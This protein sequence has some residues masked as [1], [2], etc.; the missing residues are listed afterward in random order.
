MPITEIAPLSLNDEAIVV[1]YDKDI[2]ESIGLIKM[3][4]WVYTLT[5]MRDTA[6]MVLKNHKVKI[7]FDEIPFDDENI[8]K[9]LSE[10]DTAGVF[11][12]ESN[13]MTSFIK[14]M[15]P[16]QFEDIIAGISLFRPGPMEQIPKYVKSLHNPETI[17]YDHELLEP[18]LDM[19]YG[20]IIYQE[21][22]MQIVRDLAGISM[23][24]TDN[25]RR[26]MSKK[27]P[28]ILRKYKD[29]FI[30]G[31]E[32]ENGRKVEGAVANGVPENI[33]DEIFNEVEAFAGY[34]FNKSHAAGYA[35]LA[36]QTAWLKYYYPVEFMAALLN[37]FLGNLDKASDY[38]QVCRKA[39]IPVL[40]PCINESQTRF[41]AKDGTIHFALGAIKNVG[42]KAIS[43]VISEREENGKFT[44]LVILLDVL[45]IWR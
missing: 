33:A 27:K 6:E 37:S 45:V 44:S 14:E 35:V 32:D 42:T 36:Y 3:D 31:G 19:T 38:I 39:N 17:S 30:Y 10:G 21:Q 2:I 4:F 13:G 9:M 20:C 25:V 7:N 16:K 22:V 43:Q 11:Q 8:Y 34:A 12:L 18:I 28:E 1:Q 23:G 40:P 15:K 24:Q 5:V 29:L 41:F 26:A